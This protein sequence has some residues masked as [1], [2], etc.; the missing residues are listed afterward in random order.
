RLE[1]LR[2]IILDEVEGSSVASDQAFREA[3]LA[4]DFCEDIPALSQS[5]I[6]QIVNIFEQAGAIAKVS[7]IHVNGWFGNYD[8]LS[9][10]RILF[11]ECFQTD[12]DLAQDQIV[13]CGDSPN[14]EPMFGFFENSVGVAN[15]LDFV[16]TMEQQPCWI[17]KN[18]TASG[19]V[20]LSE[21]ILNARSATSI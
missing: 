20:E 10:T 18:R 21:V 14:D 1:Q 9:M 7:S 5:A 17:T 15:V 13:F 19:F 3:D 6:D 16:D 11:A 12:M 2:K 4:I 8:K